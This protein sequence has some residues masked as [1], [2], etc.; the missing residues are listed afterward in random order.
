MPDRNPLS[1]LLLAALML[2][3]GLI[4]GG[5]AAGIM[6]WRAPATG[7]DTDVRGYL[8]AHPQVLREAMEKLQQA[9]AADQA[10]KAK[11]ALAQNEDAVLVPF[12]GA[13]A[14][15][16]NGDLT[17]A[18]YTDYA[19]TFC[20]ASLPD[21]EK[22]LASDPKLRIV[23]REWPI[24][25]PGSNVAA[26]WGLAAAEQGQDHYFAFHKALFG[27]GQ[28]SQATIDAAAVA[29]GLDLAKAQAAL[30]SKQVKD[31]VARNHASAQE[32]GATGTPTWVIGDQVISGALGLDA[33]RQAIAEARRKS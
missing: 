25:G 27:Q 23:F 14:G 11:A 5:V 22:L 16:P 12:E 7:G 28:L 2:V 8:L 1:P 26:T 6:A 18:M 4:G 32:I 19:C 33:L 13:W 30:A 21:V 17:I 29:A 3:S 20:R 15:N 24:L 10:R 31:E 9:D